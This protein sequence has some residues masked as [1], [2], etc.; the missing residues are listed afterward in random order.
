MAR[1]TYNRVMFSLPEG[2]VCV[3]WPAKMSAAEF[4]DVQDLMALVIRQMKQ[5]VQPDPTREEGV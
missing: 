2:P 1:N 3:Q 5:T 4:V